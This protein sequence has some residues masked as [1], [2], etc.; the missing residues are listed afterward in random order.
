[1][2]C[3]NHDNYVVIHTAESGTTMGP[4][5]YIFTHGYKVRWYA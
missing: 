2:Y 3:V 1:M 4:A 5:L